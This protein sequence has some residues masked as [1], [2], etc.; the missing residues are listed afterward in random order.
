MTDAHRRQRELWNAEHT[1]PNMVENMDHETPSIGV[2]RF[3]EWMTANGHASPS[4]MKG[5]EMGCGKGRNCI[6]LAEQ[7]VAMTGFDF[8]D[9]ALSEA[10]KRA[11][12]KHLTDGKLEL[13]E[14]DATL[15][16]PWPDNAFD[17][18]I[19]CFAST[20]IENPEGRAFARNEFMRVLKPGGL[21]FIYAISTRSPFHAE[22]LKTSPQ[23]ERNTYAHPSGKVD[24]IYDEREVKKFYSSFMLREFETIRKLKGGIFYGK[25]H[26]CE[27]FWMIVE[28]PPM[29]NVPPELKNYFNHQRQ[30][31]S[32]PSKPKTQMLALEFFAEKFAWEKK[33]TEK[34]VNDLLTAFHTFKDPALLRRELYMK[35][36]LDRKLD[37]SEYWRTQKV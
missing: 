31:T 35:R 3:W 34:E 10:R 7:G 23:R 13:R 18:G 12:A 14:Q 5:L 36:F 19:D 8:S 26:D 9:V 22:L 37:G 25:A 11:Q 2:T 20:D 24:K 1:T 6:W 27:N 16:W 33:Y 32:W 15:T 30:M 21:L 4:K 29:L 28:K 17:I